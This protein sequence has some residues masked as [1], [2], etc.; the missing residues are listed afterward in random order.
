MRI[1]P[2]LCFIFLF[3]S[4]QAQISPQRSQQ[5]DSIV[6][7]VR[8]T[9]LVDLDSLHAYLHNAG[10]D[11]AERVFLFY[12]LFSIHYRYDQS[13]AGSGKVKEYT[14]Y[15][16]CRTR[17]G[18]C[19][20]FSALFKELC[21]RS[22]IPCFDVS[23]RARGPIKA[24]AKDF[25]LLR[26]RRANHAWNVVKYDS[27]WHLMDPTWTHIFRVDKYYV[28]DENGRSR[29]TGKSKRGSRD[30]YDTESAEF[31]KKRNALHP[32]F[33]LSDTVYTYNSARRTVF[34]KKIQETNYD[35]DNVLD[36]LVADSL[37]FLNYAYIQEMKT[38]A[39]RSDFSNDLY[40]IKSFLDL[41]R[42]TK[43][44]LT[45]ESC[46]AYLKQLDRYSVYMKTH[47]FDEQ[48]YWQDT[49]QEILEYIEKLK[50]RQAR[51]S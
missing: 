6:T 10:S 44:P 16:T 41:K 31:Y 3:G 35:F 13:R 32:A 46:E 12:G 50:R 49:R 21:D 37:Y 2:I 43:N 8:R 42:T 40:F 26:P 25:I 4:A 34:R 47:G 19:R 11:D 22:G 17:K 28:T 24:A 36:S 18:V 30:F 23:G 29:Y 15:Y 9:I 38:Y 1:C 48:D 51:Q 5:L 14:P 39:H 7:N 20:D 45:I 33:Y 27:T